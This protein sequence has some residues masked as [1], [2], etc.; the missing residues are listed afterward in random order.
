MTDNENQDV[1]MVDIQNAFIQTDTTDT[2]AGRVMM[3]LLIDMLQ[4]MDPK[5]Y[6]DKVVYNGNIKVLYVWV[7]K[8]IYG[9][10]Q[11]AL[12]FY[13]KLCNN[14]EEEGYKVNP[15]DPCIVNKQIN[16]AQHTTT[17]HVDDLKASH[18]DL[19]VND[20]FIK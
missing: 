9:M 6:T 2:K 4:E 1:A 16:G 13:K 10:L 14:L 3:T 19:K 12:L 5:L 17:W 11:S 20:Q 8:A 18:I 7:L 15:Y